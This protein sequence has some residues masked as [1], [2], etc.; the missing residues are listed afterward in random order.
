MKMFLLSTVA[1]VAVALLAAYVL[2]DEFQFTAAEAYSTAS[3]RVGDPGENLVD[4]R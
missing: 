1:V 4:W 3:V 2:K